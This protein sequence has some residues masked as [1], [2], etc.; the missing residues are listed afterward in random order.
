MRWYLRH[1]YDVGLGVCIIALACGVLADLNTLQQILLLSFAVLLL[2]EFEEYGWPGGG[3]TFMNEVMRP[4]DVPDRYP[5]NQLNSMVVNVLAGYP[6][7][8]LPVLFPHTI[9]LGLAP[10]LFGYLEVLLHC[11]GGFLRAKVPYNPGLVTV[12]PWLVLST[13]YIVEINRQDLI[14]ASDWWIASGYLLVFVVV[15]MGLVGYVLLADRNS[16]YRF[17][18]E[19]ISRFE[20]YRRFIHAHPHPPTAPPAA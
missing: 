13:W 1:W 7:Y 15:L 18:P 9:W 17:A 14:T 11:G 8:L 10:I 6:F 5:L 16:P 4:S 20:K 12:V 2:H 3:A 19:E